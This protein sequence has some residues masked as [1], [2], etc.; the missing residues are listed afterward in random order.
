MVMNVSRKRLFACPGE[1]A[2]RVVRALATIVLLLASSPACGGGGGPPKQTVHDEA[3]RTCVLSA[4]SGPKE[5]SCDE[6]PMPSISCKADE[7]A[8]FQLGTTGDAAGPGAVCAACCG[9][10][11]S[12]SVSADCENLSCSSADDCPPE[13][14]RCVSGRCRY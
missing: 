4:A 14:G 10:T 7:S 8:C 5:L 12:H 11:S 13:Y 3:G 2:S 1:N 6:D 9:K